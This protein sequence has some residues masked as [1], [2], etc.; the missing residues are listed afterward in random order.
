MTKDEMLSAFSPNKGE[1]NYKE[2]QKRIKEA[3]E[4]GEMYV[5][6][7]GKNNTSAFSW[8]ATKETIDRLKEDGF[9]IDDIWNPWEYWSVEWYN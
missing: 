4:N 1:N 9:T 6:L 2:A 3:M 7:P 8:H 5:Y